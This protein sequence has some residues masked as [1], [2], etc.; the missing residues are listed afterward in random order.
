MTRASIIVL[1]LIFALRLI[2]SAWYP[3]V[4]IYP[5]PFDLKLLSC[6]VIQRLE[7]LGYRQLEQMFGVSQGS[8]AHFTKRLLKPFWTPSNIIIIICINQT[9]LRCGCLYN[10]GSKVFLLLRHCNE[11][12]KFFS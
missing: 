5:H 1:N 9:R 10:K 6:I 2:D 4:T 11:Y 7:N 8:V 12:E 3:T